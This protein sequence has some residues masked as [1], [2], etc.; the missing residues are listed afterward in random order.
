MLL[1]AAGAA[2]WPATGRADGLHRQQ[3]ELFGSPCTLLVPER[4]PLAAPEAW[5]LWQRLRHLHQEWNAWKP[6]LLGGINAALRA[7]RPAAVPADLHAVLRHAQRLEATTGGL[8]NAGLG[9]LVGGW[10]FH[11][12]RLGPGPAPRAALLQ[13]WRAAPPGLVHA[14][15]RAGHL[16]GNHPALQIDLGAYAKGWAV[17]EALSGLQARGVHDAL[18]DLGGNLAAIGQGAEGPWRVGIRDPFGAGLVASLRTRGREAVVTSG[19]YERFRRVEGGIVGHVIDPRSARPA[20]GVVSVTVV[21]P[22]AALAD[23]ATTALLVAGA[24][25]W[26]AVA[27]R[28]GVDQVL[29]IE[30]DGRASAH[31][32]LARRLEGTGADWR[33]DLRI[34]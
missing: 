8:F 19:T 7:G 1:G 5:R 14:G 29:V 3:L 10:G 17:D 18:L 27:E 33:R 26:P 23:A 30:R 16:I 24:S 21:H 4:A 25:R 2:L 11:A 32:R 13:R 9:A 20:E 15:F 31:E 28:L 34:V 6:G 12:D 22:C